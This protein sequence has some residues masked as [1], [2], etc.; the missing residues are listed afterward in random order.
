MELTRARTGGEGNNWRNASFTLW[1][2]V[3][4]AGEAD[5]TTVAY[6]QQLFASLLAVAGSFVVTSIRIRCTGFRKTHNHIALCAVVT[7]VNEPGVHHFLHTAPPTRVSNPTISGALFMVSRYFTRV[8]SYE[9]GTFVASSCNI[10][11]PVGSAWPL[12]NALDL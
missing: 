3:D 2:A 5:G 8:S 4:E 1:R 10:A 12:Q 6:A 7:P 9:S 11:H